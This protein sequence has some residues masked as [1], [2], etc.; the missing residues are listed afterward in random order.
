VPKSEGKSRLTGTQPPF[1]ENGRQVSRVRRTLVAR[2]TLLAVSTIASVCTIANTA[3]YLMGVTNPWVLASAF[4]FFAVSLVGFLAYE[5]HMRR[6]VEVDLKGN[7]QAATQQRDGLARQFEDCRA[8]LERYTESLG[9][10]HEAAHELRDHLFVAEAEKWTD[11]DRQKDLFHRLT[12]V[13]DELVR[14]FCVLTQQECAACVK[15]FSEDTDS[16]GG[17]LLITFC[18]DR[19]S[20]RKR[21]QND[22]QERFSID[23]NHDFLYIINSDKNYFCSNDLVNH[24][25]YFNERPDFDKRYRSAIVVPVQR[26]TVNGEPADFHDILGFL[27]VDSL[28]TNVFNEMESV[29]L[30]GAVADTMYWP[31]HLLQ[32]KEGGNGN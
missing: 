17:R 28:K 1:R 4:W 6:S 26:S 25:G 3:I 2:S 11:Q 22:G 29:K 10:F 9:L 24:E 15:L 12:A 23:K 16:E 19:Q 32:K 14:V 7:L 21:G 27:C 8:E 30:L 5:V 13:L 20:K 18:R 31:L